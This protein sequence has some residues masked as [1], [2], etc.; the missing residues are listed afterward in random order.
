MKRDDAIVYMRIA[1]YHEDRK[2]FTRLLVENR[3]R[4]EVADEAFA[5]GQKQRAAGMGCHCYQCKK[6]SA[7]TPPGHPAPSGFNHQ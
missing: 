7:T 6:A 3:V 1:G 2:G 5:V 4:R